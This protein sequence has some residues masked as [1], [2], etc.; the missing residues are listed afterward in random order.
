ME[1]N[2]TKKHHSIFEQIKK[3]DENGV[4]YWSAREL[5]KILEY[6]DFRNFLKVIDK[7]KEARQNSDQH[8]PNHFV[9]INEMVAKQEG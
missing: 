7:A 6:T 2:I 8:I 1:D 3:T 9:D 5:G 4:E